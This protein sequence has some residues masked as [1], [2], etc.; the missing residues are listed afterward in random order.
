MERLRQSKTFPDFPSR[1]VKDAFVC[2]KVEGTP[3][4]K[5]SGRAAGPLHSQAPLLRTL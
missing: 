3:K 2:F 1:R 4:C 5:V